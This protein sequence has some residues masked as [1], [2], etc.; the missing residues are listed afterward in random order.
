MMNIK[1]ECFEHIPLY[2][3]GVLVSDGI[4]I[5]SSTTAASAVV[6]EVL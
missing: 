3:R 4:S 5:D 1:L 2:S 6:V